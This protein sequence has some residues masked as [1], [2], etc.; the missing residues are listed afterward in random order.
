MPKSK[1]SQATKATVA[2][3]GLSVQH[4]SQNKTRGP[5]LRAETLV[6]RYMVCLLLSTMN[7]RFGD[8]NPTPFR[9]AGGDVG[10]R[11]TLP[12]GICTRGG[13]TRARALGFRA[14]RGGPPTR[15]GVAL[16]APV[17]GDGRVWARRSSA[18]HFQG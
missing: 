10:H 18:I 1:R 13:S 3:E 2:A 12:N 9:S 14:H 8:L 17:A 6:R 4:R 5:G 16:E 11:P 7:P 15:R